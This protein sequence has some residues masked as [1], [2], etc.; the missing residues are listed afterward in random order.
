MKKI[1]PP[2]PVPVRLIDTTA[3]LTI[4]LFC[5]RLLAMEE[6]LTHIDV[7]LDDDL[8]QA[9]DI[10]RDLVHQKN[11]IVQLSHGNRRDFED[12]TRRL[13]QVIV[14]NAKRQ[15]IAPAVSSDLLDP[16]HL[17]FLSS[18]LTDGWERGQ[19][20]GIPYFINHRDQRTQWDHPEF[21][22]LMESLLEMNTVKFSVYRM[23]LK[24]RK[25]Q[26]KLCLD[27]LDLKSAQFAFN[28]HGLT[29]DKDDS[30]IAVPQMIVVLTSI[31][32]A[33]HE[34][35]PEEVIVALC[36]DLC[37]N[38]LL[39]VFD[40][41]RASGQIR[42]L[43]FKV[44]LLVLCRGPLTEKYIQLYN[45]V[46]TGDTMTPR[47]LALLLFDAIQIPRYLAEVAAFG[48]SDIE[49]S[50]RSCFAAKGSS[51]KNE[52]EF[53]ETLSCKQFIQWLQKEPQ[54]MVWLPVLHRLSAAEM[55]TH[56]TK[57]RACK[58]FPIVG[59]R[60]HCLKCFNFDLCHNCFFVGRTAKGHKADH[61]T[62]E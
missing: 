33:L 30:L 53:V 18:V 2:P 6:E 62:Q 59:F 20:D 52:N 57:C 51:G 9:D 29:A 26:Q 61:P 13:K 42:V 56:N 60:Y 43:S 5:N 58:A 14:A 45:L 54:S 37:L 1:V 55:A 39:N 32:E 47:Q 25:V 7:D 31:Y 15:K 27:L 8:A 3:L 48:G 28:E 41:A 40:T 16:N 38:W 11:N 44:G 46:S 17:D 23:A 49:P 35:E 34:E 21:S 36:I 50:V 22:D 19:E 10:H 24:L 4:F 12:L